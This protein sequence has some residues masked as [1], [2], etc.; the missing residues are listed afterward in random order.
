M[1]TDQKEEMIT[2]RLNQDLKAK[3]DEREEINWSGVARKAIR[4]TIEDL[5]TIDEIASQNQMTEEEAED[6]AEQI[7]EAANKRAQ[8]AHEKDEDETSTHQV[9]DG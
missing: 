1:S 8:T 3:M 9:M 4:T 6:I 5:E 7:T 2:V